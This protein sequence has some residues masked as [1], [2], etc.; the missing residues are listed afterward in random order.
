MNIQHHIKTLLYR[1]DCVIVSGLGGF[2]C[3]LESARIENNYVIPPSKKLSFNQ[4][5]NS[6]DGLLENHVAKYE[7]VSYQ[8]A[9]HNILEFSQKI[10]SSLV[11]E[12][13]V[14]LNGLGTFKYNDNSNLVFEP[15]ASQEWY[16]EAYGLPKFKL[17]PVVLQNKK[18]E[19]PNPM[20]VVSERPKS[21]FKTTD[22]TARPI[23]AFLKYA[24]VGVIAIGIAGIFGAEVYKN[25]VEAHNI[26]E[27]EK[28]NQLVEQKIQK[29]SFVFNE[30]L[31]PLSVE[32]EAKK[33]ELGK[34]H[35]VGGAFRIKANVEKKIKQL[36]KKGFDARYIGTNS[37]GLHQ[38]VYGS[39][40]DKTEALKNLRQIKVKENS[41]A[42]LFVKEL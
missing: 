41:A 33:K 24:A 34:Y 5:L 37:Y 32:V 28:A 31:K 23:S 42:W 18:E 12:D 20:M 19:K 6:G 8:I 36:Q 11:N 38:V 4:N 13:E 9:Q 16:L 21:A 26:A 39:Y 10:K 2:I 25:K 7:K 3:K 14:V 29:S 1:H 27:L 15:E 22:K 17:S 40:T 30:P 35:I